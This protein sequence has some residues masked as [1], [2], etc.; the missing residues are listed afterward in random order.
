MAPEALA[1]ALALRIAWRTAGLP[2]NPALEKIPEPDQPGT[3][4]NHQFSTW[5]STT[6]LL[7]SRNAETCCYNREPKAPG[8]AR[9]LGL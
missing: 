4:I 1:R 3:P 5:R 7:S 9:R 8:S 2:A 6:A